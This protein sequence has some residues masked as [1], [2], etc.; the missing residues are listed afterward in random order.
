MKDTKRRLEVFSFYDRAHIERHLE[1]MAARG[2]LQ[3]R[4][5]KFGWVYRRI[6][7]KRLT[8]HV[9]YFPD[10]SDFDPG[11]TWGQLTFQDFC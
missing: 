2:W 4:M 8:F 11:P 3:E 1:A 7:P 9:S 10:A 5:G 6:E